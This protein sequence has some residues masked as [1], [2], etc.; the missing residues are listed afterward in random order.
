MFT[1]N[2]YDIIMDNTALQGVISNSP[3]LIKL[4]GEHSAYMWMI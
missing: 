1:E 2:K 4:I 3:L